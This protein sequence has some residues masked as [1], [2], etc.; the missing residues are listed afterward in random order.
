MLKSKFSYAEAFDPLI[1]NI[2]QNGMKAEKSIIFCSSYN[3]HDQQQLVLHQPLPQ[4]QFDTAIA[5][6]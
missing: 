6:W 1:D 2:V 3:D 4:V 5:E